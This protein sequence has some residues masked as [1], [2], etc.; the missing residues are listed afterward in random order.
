MARL[1]A[2]TIFIKG[3]DDESWP[4]DNEIIQTTRAVNGVFL[5]I[6]QPAV[7]L[8]IEPVRWGGECRVEI[9]VNAKVSEGEQIQIEGNVKLFEGISE[10]TQD[11]GEEKRVFFLVPKTTRN[12]PLPATYDVQLNN[13][14][15]GG[16]DHS[17]IS[18]TFT[19][20]IVE[21]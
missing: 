14:G 19:N 6:N 17:E 4:F 2:G 1:L 21:D 8:N 9:Q 18:F 11:L 13:A 12:Q 20:H 5:D 16:G 10:N 15:F 3:T 7:E